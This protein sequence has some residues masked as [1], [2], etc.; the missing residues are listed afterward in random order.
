MVRAWL[1]RIRLPLSLPAAETSGLSACPLCE[2]DY[3]V[4]VEWEPVGEDRWWIY[5]R[6]AQCDTAREITVAN[7]VAERYDE[8]LAEGERAIKRAAQRLELQRMAGEA[9]VFA[10]KLHSGLIEPDDFI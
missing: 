1:R 3:V 10:A 4:P 7:A 6:C 2:K 5:L 8:E 9:D